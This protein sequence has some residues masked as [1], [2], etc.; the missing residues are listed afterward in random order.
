MNWEQCTTFRKRESEGP[1]I[2]CVGVRNYGLAQERCLESMQ[3][4]IH[5]HTAPSMREAVEC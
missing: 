5:L 4:T 3:A 1:G 2:A